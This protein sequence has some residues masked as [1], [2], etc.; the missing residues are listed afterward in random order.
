MYGS[1]RDKSLEK[2]FGGRFDAVTAGET[3][4]Q[5]LAGAAPD[6]LLELS[7]VDRR[8]IFKLGYFTGG[9]QQGVWGGEFSARRDQR[10]WRELRALVPAWDEMIG[11]LNQRVGHRPQ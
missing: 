1:E 8:R 6:R 3:Y 5:H 2:R 7:L 11:E 4:G 9:G 10:F